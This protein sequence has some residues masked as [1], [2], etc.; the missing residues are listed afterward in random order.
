MLPTLPPLHRGVGT[1]LRAKRAPSRSPPPPDFPEICLFHLNIFLISSFP[2]SAERV[3][4]S[5]ARRPQPVAMATR[6]PPPH[7]WLPPPRLLP[8]AGGPSAGPRPLPLGPA[9][10]S[11]PPLS[12]RSPL[13]LE[14]APRWLRPPT[15]RATGARRPPPWSGARRTMPFPTTSPSSVSGRPGGRVPPPPLSLSPPQ[16]LRT[17]TPLT[18]THGQGNPPSSV[19]LLS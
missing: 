6:G 18:R 5:R 4:P 12:P 1:A 17:P 7:N 10:F 9:P 2:P 16:P 8:G 11:L 15:G 14:R 3:R 13:A 19:A